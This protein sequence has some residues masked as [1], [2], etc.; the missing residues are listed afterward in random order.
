MLGFSKGAHK[1][2]TLLF[3]I[4]IA[5]A[6]AQTDGPSSTSREVNLFE[7]LH[8]E[9][10]QTRESIVHHAGRTYRKIEYQGQFFYLRISEERTGA[11]LMELLC[12]DDPKVHEMSSDTNDLIEGR[13]KISER[14]QLFVEALQLKC[15]GPRHKRKLVLSPEM[16]MGLRFDDKPRDLIKNKK[17][18]VSPGPGTGLGFSG[19]W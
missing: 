4:S 11:D 8:P 2:L 1:M 10:V 14:M 7:G 16:K 3:G 15:E 17:I 12:G 9:A 18:Y 19:E 6:K 5:V 13:I